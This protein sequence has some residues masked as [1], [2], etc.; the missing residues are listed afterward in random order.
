MELNLTP[1]AFLDPFCH[2]PEQSPKISLLFVL[3]A[4]TPSPNPRLLEERVLLLGGSSVAILFMR[5]RG[6]QLFF[7]L[8]QLV[9]LLER[10]ITDI[11]LVAFS[12]A[13]TI[14]QTHAP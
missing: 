13:S 9:C 2:H 1:A 3:T 4:L 7:L 14:P 11:H 5:L 6:P 8:L 10:T 12:L